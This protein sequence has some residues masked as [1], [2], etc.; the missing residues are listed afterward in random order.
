M[1]QPL[2]WNLSKNHIVKVCFYNMVDITKFGSG[3]TYEIF[4]PPVN[5]RDLNN[6]NLTWNLNNFFHTN[7][8]LNGSKKAT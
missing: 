6:T 2:P 4:K 8:G 7:Q 5:K 1:T 3:N